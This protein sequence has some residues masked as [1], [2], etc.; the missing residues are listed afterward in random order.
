MIRVRQTRKLSLVLRCLYSELET[1]AMPNILAELSKVKYLHRIV[2]GLDRADETQY[3]HAKDF[4]KGLNQNHIVIWNGSPRMQALESRLK[5]LK[6][7]QYAGDG[8]F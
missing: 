2:I 4:F 1:D 7:P 5:E 8:K 3:R 6:L